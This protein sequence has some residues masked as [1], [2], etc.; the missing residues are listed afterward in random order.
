MISSGITDK[1]M[2][3]I[4]ALI[5]LHPSARSRSFEN[6]LSIV[7]KWKDTR[8][9]P[10]SVR[11]GWKMGAP[12]AIPRTPRFTKNI[13]ISDKYTAAATACTYIRTR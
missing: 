8:F 13:R 11:A 3:F 12:R 9:S 1:R 2:R 5:L 10:L 7:I 4:L 6:E